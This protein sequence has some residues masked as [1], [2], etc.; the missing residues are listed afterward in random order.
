MPPKKAHNTPDNSDLCKKLGIPLVPMGTIAEM[1]SAQFLSVFVSYKQDI[2]GLINRV[3]T[4]EGKMETLEKE[5]KVV[6]DSSTEQSQAMQSLCRRVEFL[7]AGIRKRSVIIGGLHCG[8]LTCR[9]AVE[10]FFLDIM[11]T[12]LPF[13]KSYRLLPRKEN[14]LKGSTRPP[15]IRVIFEDSDSKAQLYS[16]LK[17]LKG[18]G[19]FIR[20]DLTD[21]ERVSRQAL[22]GEMTRARSEGKTAKVRGKSL[23]IDGIRYVHKNDLI[24]PALRP[25]LA[26]GVPQDA[27]AMES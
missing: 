26:Q 16:N 4:L 19:Y 1:T 23:I 8:S 15:L 24:I 6:S 11:Q 25:E 14:K 2:S 20:D 21:A 9:K 3:T 10:N 27:P 17:H 18:T 13:E 7:E 5:F 12:V 22:V